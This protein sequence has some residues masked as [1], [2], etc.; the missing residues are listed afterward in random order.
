MTDLLEPR[1][2]TRTPEGPSD[3]GRPPALGAALAGLAAA[4]SGMAGCVVLAVIGG[5]ATESGTLGTTND[6]LRVGADAWLLAQ[7]AHLHLAAG[8]ATATITAGPL[9]LTLVSLWAAHR[10]GR[11][12]VRTSAIEDA[13]T[14]L[15]GMGILSGV[16]ALV[17][18]P[19]SM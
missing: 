8:S 12:A 16:Y 1:R 3:D 9:G 7:G 5:L 18:L 2:A 19:T 17:S 10:A 14:L 13:S 4:L 15:L 6:A 11:W